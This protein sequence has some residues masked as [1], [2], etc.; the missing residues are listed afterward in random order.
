MHKHEKEGE[1]RGE[2]LSKSGLLKSSIVVDR[3][4][5]LNG[6]EFKQQ[7]IIHF[8]GWNLELIYLASGQDMA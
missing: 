2:L 4:M 5:E 6:E 8:I 7:Y 1:S 3:T